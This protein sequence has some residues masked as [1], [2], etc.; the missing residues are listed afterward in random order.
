MA[1]QVQVNIL[2]IMYSIRKQDNIDI[3]YFG[4]VKKI[5][6]KA[7]NYPPVMSLLRATYNEESK[8]FT[9]VEESEEEK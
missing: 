2:I 6:K 9:F 4:G 1:E 3:K 8:E 7:K 5:A